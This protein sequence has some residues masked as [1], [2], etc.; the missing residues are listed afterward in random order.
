MF[1][2]FTTVFMR[3]CPQFCASGAI[4]I[5]RKTRYMFERYDQNLIVFSI[6]GRF[7]EL[8]PTVLGVPGI[9]R[10]TVRLDTCLRFKSKNSSFSRFMAILLSY[11]P[12]FWGTRV[13]YDDRRTGYMF[14]SY[15]QKLVVFAFYDRFHEILPTVLGL[16]GDLIAHKTQYMFERYDQN[17]IVFLFYGNFHE[18]LPTVLALQ[19]Y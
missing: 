9:F 14:Q 2:R 15:D 19:G 7:H 13:I 11:W 3:Y 17:L 6:Y 16:R 5:A 4:C 12:H 8:L 10:K 18:L 1:S